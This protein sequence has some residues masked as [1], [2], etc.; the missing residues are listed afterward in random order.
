MQPTAVLDGPDA[1]LPTSSTRA[2]LELALVG[3]GALAAS[4]SQALLIP[5][6]GKLPEE[7]PSHPSEGA[8][9]W[10][11]TSTLLV[12]AVAVPLFGRLGDM[13]GK[14]RLLLVSLGLLVV[15]SVLTAVTDDIGLLIAGRAIQGASM[16]SIPL[17]ISLLA[18][19]L[20]RERVGSGIAVIS[21]MLGVGGALAMPIGGLIGQHADYHWIFW[22]TAVIGA[23]AVAGIALV[24]PEAP[25]RTPG[26]VDLPGTVLLSGALVALLLPL[27]ETASWGW[28]DVRTIGLL[29]AALV[30]FVLFGAVETRSAE[31]LVDLTALRRRPIVLT[32]TASVLLG[33]SM[34]AMMIGVANYVQAPDQSGY[35]FG[36][37]IVVSGLCMLPGGLMM[38]LL[39]P[40]SARGIRR[41]GAPRMM[42]AGAVVVALGWLMRIV[43]T[44]TL[45]EVVVG[46]TISGMGVALAYAAMPTLINT[47][48]PVTEIAAANGLNS[49]ARSIGS[50]LAS[51]I[52]GS[53]LAGSVVVATVDGH[54]TGWSTLGSYQVL[55]ALSA[56]AG[57]VSAGIALLVPRHAD[58]D[59]LPEV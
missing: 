13:F 20:P 22:L 43:L 33:F 57:V 46:T 16:A 41:F 51:A 5:V 10:L 45:W 2:T 9:E 8:I 23:V 17:G 39:S 28:G 30:L 50:S 14:R 26:R 6:L 7:I 19:L 12:A 34:F 1:T 59:A 25:H 44:D 37:S 55:F 4:M 58:A 35:G 21:A 40:V 36:S 15:G 27:A 52:G 56:I 24:V 48:T 11:L 49:L 3:A 38:L 47:H 42:A 29:V 53:I 54:V 32:N 31:P 18:S